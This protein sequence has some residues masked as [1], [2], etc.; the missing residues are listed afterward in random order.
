MKIYLE[1]NFF[2]GKLIDLFQIP[3][4]TMSFDEQVNLYVQVIDGVPVQYFQKHEILVIDTEM[5]LKE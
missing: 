1:K 4:E 5:K 2:D 3:S